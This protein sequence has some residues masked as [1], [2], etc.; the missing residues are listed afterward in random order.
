MVEENLTRSESM[1]GRKINKCKRFSNK[2]KN[3]IPENHESFLGGGTDRGYS[4]ELAIFHININKNVLHADKLE[5]IQS[6]TKVGADII[7]IY[8]PEIAE[9]EVFPEDEF[10]NYKYWEIDR[11]YLIVLTQLR[12]DLKVEKVMGAPAAVAAKVLGRS[13]MAFGCYN[14]RS[15]DRLQ[16]HKLE[17]YNALERAQHIREALAAALHGSFHKCVVGGDWNI[18][19]TQKNQKVHANGIRIFLEQR[20]FVIDK[21]DFTRRPQTDAQSHTKPDWLASRG[22]PGAVMETFMVPQSDHDLVYFANSKEV[23][24]NKKTTKKIEVWKFGKEAEEMANK[25]SPRLNYIENFNDLS[26]DKLTEVTQDFLGKVND[27]CKKTIEVRNYGLPYYNSRLLQEQKAILECKDNKTRKVMLS[28]HK[29]NIKIARQNWR[30]SGCKNSQ[31]PWPRNSN[32]PPK[33]YVVTDDT[34]GDSVTLTDDF[35]M[36]EAQGHYWKTSVEKICEDNGNNDEEPVIERFKKKYVEAKKSLPK[37]DPLQKEW[38]FKIPSVAD[39]VEVIKKSKPKASAAFDEISHR[40]V[41]KCKW[42]VAPILTKL[43]GKIILTSEFPDALKEIKLVAVHKSGKPRNECSSYRPIA[44]QST[45]AKILDMYLCQE[46][47]RIT[48]QLQ[49]LPGNVHGY[50]KF[51]SC[52]SALRQLLEAFDL[53]K[54][55]NMNLCILGLDYSKAYDTVSLTLCPK[56]IGAL[57]AGQSS[58]MLLKNFLAGRPSRVVHKKAKA[59]PYKMLMGILQGAATSPKIF[60]VITIDKEEIL[61]NLCDGSILYADDSLIF[62]FYEKTE[63]A[64]AEVVKKIKKAAEKIEDW[65]KQ[66][67][68]KLNHKKTELIC[69]SNCKK[70]NCGDK[71]KVDKIDLFGHEVKAAEEFKFV[72][73]HLNSSGGLAPHVRFVLKKMDKNNAVLRRLAKGTSMAHKR[74]LFNGLILSNILCS[75]SAW[76]PRLS[77]TAVVKLQSKLQRCL[78]SISGVPKFGELNFDGTRYSGKNNYNKFSLPTVQELQDQFRDVN[79]KRHYDRHRFQLLDMV[80]ETSAGEA[81]PNLEKYKWDSYVKNEFHAA[82]SNPDS[83]IKLESIKDIVNLHKAKREIRFTT[84]NKRRKVMCNAKRALKNLQYKNVDIDVAAEWLAKQFAKDDVV[85]KKI[86][87]HN[88]IELAHSDE[89]SVPFWT[90]H[91]F[92]SF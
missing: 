11:K 41:K 47:T 76:L 92:G 38:N 79:T 77:S 30:R 13:F 61:R 35:E 83:N 24:F 32:N 14:R 52:A 53:A 21:F 20:G 88:K 1:K 6:Y 45:I 33:E 50:R 15:K 44:I 84:F 19:I 71:C 67:Q 60:S 48:D 8:E 64:K 73:L 17:P 12:T 5:V 86:C 57:G 37:N 9:N 18:D 74:S 89:I 34:T 54:A 51:H 22:F 69:F 43:I 23:E 75:G 78:R 27:A 26:I 40:L 10:P 49:V 66:V 59:N 3:K 58:V 42:H 68:L 72:G 56:I 16:G 62:W 90:S 55:K 31:N 2:V 65:A 63:E 4:S 7:F 81:R 87:N 25:L 85:V 29:K 28:V 46:I 80:K 82:K 36:A 39:I 70:K 91:V